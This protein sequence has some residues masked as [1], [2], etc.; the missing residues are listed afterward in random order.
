ME[1][2]FKAII[3]ATTDNYD[4][5]TASYAPTTAGDW[6]VLAGYN[7]EDHPA[8][9]YSTAY[10]DQVGLKV[11]GSAPT[12]TPTSSETPPPSSTS[13]PIATATPSAVPTGTPTQNTGTDMTYVY[14]G[15]AI[16][17]IIIIV[18]AAVLLMRRKK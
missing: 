11:S 12:S 13:T 10:S 16:V 9:S 2:K 3:A 18:L 8:F 1:R 5:A 17:V 6:A 7:G 15:I 4:V 14:A